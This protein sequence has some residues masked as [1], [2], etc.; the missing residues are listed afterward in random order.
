MSSLDTTSNDNIVIVNRPFDELNG[1]LNSL[2]AGHGKKTLTHL[3]I[4]RGPHFQMGEN[5][6]E[7][8]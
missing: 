8:V 5:P 3:T 7:F 1:E 4:C 2:S 6:F